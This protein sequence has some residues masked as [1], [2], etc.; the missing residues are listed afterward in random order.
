MEVNGLITA[1][2]VVVDGITLYCSGYIGSPYTHIEF[3]ST[4]AATLYTLINGVKTAV[5]TWTAGDTSKY[6]QNISDISAHYFVIE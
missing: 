3:S 1:G 5:K 4:R 6:T 2:S